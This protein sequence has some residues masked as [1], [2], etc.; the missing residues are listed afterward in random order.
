MVNREGVAELGV[1]PLLL[2]LCADQDTP[3]E[4]VDSAN[5]LLEILRIDHEGR[6]KSKRRTEEEERER[7][8]QEEMPMLEDGDKVIV[9]KPRDIQVSN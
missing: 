2:R 4:V 1:G 3:E 7:R 9:A 5:D 6:G 8:E